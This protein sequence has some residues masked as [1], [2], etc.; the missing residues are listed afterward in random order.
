MLT[1]IPFFRS[2]SPPQESPL[3]LCI[4]KNILAFV[5]CIKHFDG[6]VQ[7]SQS[8]SCTGKTIL[9]LSIAPASPHPLS[10]YLYPEHRILYQ[11]LTSSEGV[12]QFLRCPQTVCFR[13]FSTGVWIIDRRQHQLHIYILWQYWNLRLREGTNWFH[14]QEKNNPSPSAILPPDLPPSIACKQVGTEYL[15]QEMKRLD[16]NFLRKIRDKDIEHIKHEVRRGNE[17][18]AHSPSISA[19]IRFISS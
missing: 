18:R 8:G 1:C 19:I 5:A 13:A 16:I 15:Y 14:G 7:D 9:L 2:I 6:A 10:S 3:L 11:I 12:Y 17:Y 4:L